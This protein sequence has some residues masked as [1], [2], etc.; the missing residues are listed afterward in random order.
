MTSRTRKV[1]GQVWAYCDCEGFW[2]LQKDGKDTRTSIRRS[3]NNQNI[4]I[5]CEGEDVQGQFDTMKEA[6]KAV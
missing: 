1:N 2:W 4:W 3:D 6:M 5:L